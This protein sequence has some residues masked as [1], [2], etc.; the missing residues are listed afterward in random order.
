[1]F[2]RWS[3]RLPI[4]LGV[5]MILLIIALIVGWVLVTTGVIA[6]SSWTLL[7]GDRVSRSHH[8]PDA[9][10]Q[11]DQSFAAAVE[12]YRQRNARAKISYRV[13]QAVPAND[14]QTRSQR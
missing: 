5:T 11:G 4:T 1:M 3:L 9:F 12:F 8:V 13:A 14:A 6:K 2:E 7:S 10:D